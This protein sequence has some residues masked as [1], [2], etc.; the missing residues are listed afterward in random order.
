MCKR[1]PFANREEISALDLMVS[2][3][4][5]RLHAE[6]LA[7]LGA[8]SGQDGTAALRRHAG[9]EAVALGALAR[10]RLIRALHGHFPFNTFKSSF[11]SIYHV[12]HSSRCFYVGRKETP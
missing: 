8:T 2:N 5:P 1:L 11:Q 6:A 4:R 10:V 7:S 3:P 9:T 12:T